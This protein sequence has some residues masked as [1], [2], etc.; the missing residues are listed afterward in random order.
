MNLFDVIY[1]NKMKHLLILFFLILPASTGLDVRLSDL[2]RE[3]ESDNP[4]YL[5]WSH[6]RQ[7]KI[8]TLYIKYSYRNK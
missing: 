3:I 4:G 5:E 6:D 2:D 1:H 7:E 8:K